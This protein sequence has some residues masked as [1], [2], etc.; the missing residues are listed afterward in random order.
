MTQNALKDRIDQMKIKLNACTDQKEKQNLA[1]LG[2]ELT[3]I[4]L[5]SCG[6]IVF[7]KEDHE[8]NVKELT[9]AF[10]WDQFSR[11]SSRGLPR[12]K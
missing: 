11:I 6:Y 2:L 3:S 5:Q 1:A 7:T 9:L 8:R 10:D 12:R 4:F